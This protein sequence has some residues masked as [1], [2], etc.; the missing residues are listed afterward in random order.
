MK[1][2]KGLYPNFVTVGDSHPCFPLLSVVGRRI[3]INL[4]TQVRKYNEILVKKN[5]FKRKQ[6]RINSVINKQVF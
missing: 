1:I 3:I 2:R 6:G 5:Y 4:F